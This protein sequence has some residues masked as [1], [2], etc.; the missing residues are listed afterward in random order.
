MA[1]RV[2]L[3][4]AL[5]VLLLGHDVAGDGGSSECSGTDVGWLWSGALSSHSITFKLGLRDGH[6]CSDRSFLMRLHPELE[7]DERPHAAIALCYATDAPTVHV[8]EAAV[9]LHAARKYRY[10]LT[11]LADDVVVRD[12]HFRTPADEGTPMSFRVAFSSCAD[13]GSDPQVR[14]S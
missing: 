5:S 7:S 2:A 1:V 12:G 4:V 14:C 9:S 10:E 11:T 8:C 13:E 3:R 6:A